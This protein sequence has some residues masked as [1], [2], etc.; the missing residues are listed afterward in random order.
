MCCRRPHAERWSCVLAAVSWEALAG[1]HSGE[2]TALRVQ[3]SPSGHRGDLAA[4]EGGGDGGG[5]NYDRAQHLW[6]AG[7]SEVVRNTVQL[8]RDP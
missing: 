4:W 5:V 8:H 3:T 6:S 2:V 7:S 1:Y